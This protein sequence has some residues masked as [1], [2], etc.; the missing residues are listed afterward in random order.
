MKWTNILIYPI[1]Y[2]GQR[3]NAH[4]F[5]TND[6]RFYYPSKLVKTNREGYVL[7]TKPKFEVRCYK[8]VQDEFGTR[9][10][11]FTKTGQDLIDRFEEYIDYSMIHVPKKLE[12][13]DRPVLEEL[14]DD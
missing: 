5:S 12:A 7:V 6:Y 9:W 8:Q 4:V 14:K 13:E 1:C 10:E 3:G 11:H 2:Q